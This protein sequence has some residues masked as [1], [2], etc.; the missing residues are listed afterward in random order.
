MSLR[1]RLDIWGEGLRGPLLAAF[2]AFLAA[3]PGLL[4]LP[5][6]DRDESRFAEASAQ[7]LE[8]GD[9]VT[10][11]FQDAPRFKKPV[12]IYWL[13]AAAVKLLGHV[14][15]RRI[16][17]Y[18]LPSL[19]GVMLAAGACAW[20]AA[21]F[22][23]PGLALVAG[24]A[25]GGGFLLAT[26]GAIGATDGALCGAATLAMSALGRLYL[27]ARGGPPAGRNSK[28]L[29]WAGLAASLLLKGPIG[30]MVFVLTLLA[31]GFSERR[32]AWMKHIGW[33][34][35]LIFTAAIAAPW[36]MAITVATDGA[37]WGAAVGGDLA[38]KLV[39]GQEGHA[40]PPGYFLILAPLALFPA[41]FLLPAAAVEAWRERRSPAIRFALCWL[42]PSWL[43]F[44]LAPTKL[45]HYTLPLYGALAWL[46]ASALQRPVGRWA[47]RIGAALGLLAGLA[48]AG[49]GPIVAV[50]LGA[51]PPAAAEIL[52]VVLYLTAAAAGAALVWTSRPARGLAAALVA[53]L[54]GHAALSAGVVPALEPLWLS[55]QAARLLTRAG[56]NPR[57]GVAPGPV[58]V[59]GYAEPSL[60][61]LLGTDTELAGPAE[62]AEAIAEGRPAVVESRV[63]PAFRAA[64]AAQR[65]Q[66]RTVGRAQGIDYSDRG[67]RETLTIYAPGAARTAA[68]GPEESAR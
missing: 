33:G 4:A 23:P 51:R 53:A 59:A 31:L 68:I 65:L 54:A 14:E 19:L 32:W 25:L 5:P 22:L 67:K 39:E 57:L 15:D 11:H 38:P 64:L 41:S 60:V 45:P 28:A 17:L 7:M 12:G 8:S 35:G 47:A 36:A 49:V 48:F 58:T 30:P 43:V 52:A 6:L 42:V 3:A 62:A 18:R 16:W 9:Y 27:A 55:S 61:F 63:D 1:T 50:Q 24:S 44:E 10:I 40:G 34:W 2:V 56:L 66:A 20:G 13:Q 29:L 21:A 46:I 37:F 26:E